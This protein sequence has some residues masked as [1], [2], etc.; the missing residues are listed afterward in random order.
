VKR[1]LEVSAQNRRLRKKK[2]YCGSGAEGKATSEWVRDLLLR[3]AIADHRSDM[4]L[5][6]FIELVGIEMLMMKTLEPVLRWR[7]NLNRSRAVHR[8]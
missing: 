5:H 2:V 4:E 3:C 8:W 1:D 7:K 6:I